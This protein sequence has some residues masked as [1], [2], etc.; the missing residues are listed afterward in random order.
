MLSKITLTKNQPQ[1]KNSKTNL[2]RIN[3]YFVDLPAN[4]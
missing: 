3:N 1:H 2:N 4:S